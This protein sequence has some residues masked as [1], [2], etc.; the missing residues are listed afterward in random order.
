MIVRRVLGMLGC[1]PTPNADAVEIA[2]LRHQLA[3]LRRQVGRAKYTPA[4]RMLLAALA[5]LLPRERWSVLLSA[6]R[7][8][9]RSASGASWVVVAVTRRPMAVACPVPAGQQV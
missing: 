5:K 9:R 3:V 1:G 7:G 8:P 4:D 6:R 2:V